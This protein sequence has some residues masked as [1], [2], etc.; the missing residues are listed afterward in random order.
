[1]LPKAKISISDDTRLVI[2]DKKKP[3]NQGSFV[4]IRN[5]LFH[6]TKYPYYF[7]FYFYDFYDIEKKGKNI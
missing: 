5:M 3:E 1:M 2:N 4:I 7:Y 6:I